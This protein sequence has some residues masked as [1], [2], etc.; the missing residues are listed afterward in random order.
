MSISGRFSLCTVFLITFFLSESLSLHAQERT[1]RPGKQ[2]KPPTFTKARE[3]AAL[4]F[5]REHYPEAVKPLAN[6]KSSNRA[7]NERTLV[8]IFRASEKLTAAFEKD[9]TEARILLRQWHNQMQRRLLTGQL[10][11]DPE[12]EQIRA[13]IQKTIEQS[14]QIEADLLQHHAQQLKQQAMRTEQ[15]RDEILKNKGQLA[16]KRFADLLIALKKVRPV[17]KPTDTQSEKLRTEL[18]LRAMGPRFMIFREGVARDVNVTK[19]QQ[20]V[21]A[22]LRTSEVEALTKFYREVQPEQRATKFQEY[23]VLADQRMTNAL[24]KILKP[25]QEERLFELQLQEQGIF[26]AF[27]DPDLA[28]ELELTEEQREKYATLVRAMQKDF[29]ELREKAKKDPT[30]KEIQ[31]EARKLRESYVRKIQDLLSEKQ[32]KRWQH[33][34]GKP[35]GE[36]GTNEKDPTKEESRSSLPNV[37]LPEKQ[38]DYAK[39]ETEIRSLK[40][41]KVAWREI[42]W[43][44]SLIEGIKESRKTKKPIILWV[45]IDRP[46]DD[47]RC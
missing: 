25:A 21:L 12:N 28:Q 45:F 22:K 10:L 40:A 24:R 23:R 18:L 20:Q 4:A 33:L 27:G 30:S 42:P 47:E 29:A 31:E 38:T 41:K 36:K 35:L 19:E 32:Q 9:P 13:Q 44:V 17:T 8:D 39:L 3:A 14:I 11:R 2:S 7:A 15:R 5:L 26:A 37:T 46:I 1:A 6:L 16:K 43:R 34:L